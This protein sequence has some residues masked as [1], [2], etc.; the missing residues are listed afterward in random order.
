M[1]KNILLLAITFITAQLH[2]QD[3]LKPIDSIV[4]LY[5]GKEIPG[6]A[7]LVSKNGKT[8]YSRN[9]GYAN[10]EKKEKITDKTVFALASTSK[11]FTA[12]CIVLLE[13]QGKLSLDDNLRK[14]MPEFPEYAEKIT[15]N[16]LLNHTAGLKDHRALAMFRGEKSDEYNSSAIKD[17]LTAQELNYQPGEKWSYSNSGYWCLAQIVEKVSGQSVA[18][19]AEKNIFKPLG[20]KDTRYVT[21]PDN[22]VKNAAAGYQNDG[23]H[24]NPSDVDEY[25]VGGA[26]VYSTAKDLQKWLAE[27]ESHRVFGPAFW[28][29][30]TAENPAQGK[31]FAYTKGLFN[32]K[33]AGRTMISHG[34]DV[35]GFHPI[36]AYFPAEKIGV[37]ILGND[38]DFKR[39]EIL[40]A[41]VDLLLGDTYD[42]P[43]VENSITEK[44]ND[45]DKTITVSPSLLESYAGNYE[46]TPGFTI[47]IVVENG[48]LRLTQL[49]D[50][51]SVLV[52]PSNETH[53]FE[54]AGANLA[55][56]NFEA[57]KATQLH[58][59][60]S[61]EDSVYNRMDKEPDFTLYD[62]YAG[63]FY[64]KALK[65][66][67]TFF[68]EKGI[69]YYKLKN[70]EPFIASPPDSEGAFST[71][72]GS[73]LFK[74]EASGNVTGFLL[75][76]ERVLNMEFLKQE[77]IKA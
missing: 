16:Q 20:M 50:L 57:G 12:A 15:I 25:A 34:G 7:V 68:T 13:K 70:S 49:W 71:S 41:A 18:L 59:V 19:F 14:Y 26:G 46:L 17:M 61:E 64:C 60:T 11:Q 55:F 32:F 74:V 31:G 2:A 75:N 35:V 73:I 10:L 54:I 77:L 9:A 51:T 63:T 40:G 22:K 56:S 58:I 37:V 48:T 67:I 29:T 42:Y 66:T 65:A 30:M 38:D 3:Y 33:Y 4:K 53:H 6:F 27:M 52:K 36:T 5:A 24:Y 23:T 44:Q 69:L 45:E 76:H 28:N 72:H 1:K 43:K 47:A 39:Y 21:K 8:L 62:K